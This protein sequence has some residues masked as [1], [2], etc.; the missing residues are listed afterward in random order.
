MINENSKI[1]NISR[2]EEM[3]KTRNQMKTEKKEAQRKK[4]SHPVAKKPATTTQ[5]NPKPMPKI[6]LSGDPFPD[7]EP[8]RPLPP[9]P[10]KV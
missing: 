7:L 6:T 8:A 5:T 2:A 9:I 10:E 1:H 4:I 3:A